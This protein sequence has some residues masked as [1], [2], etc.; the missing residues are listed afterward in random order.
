VLAANGIA[1]APE[2]P[3]TWRAFLRSHAEV[4]AAVDFFTTEVWT[5]RGLVTC[6]TLFAIDLRTRVVEMLGSTLHPDGAFMAQ[7]AR[8]IIDPIDGF[9]RKKRYLLA[10]RDTKFTARFR[11]IL[12]QGGVHC[13][14]LPVAA[15]NS[16]AYAER[17][18]RSIKSECLDRLILIGE[19][20]LHRALREY[21]AHYNRERNHQGV[22][23]RLLQPDPGTLGA[24]GPVECRKR[25]GGLL[26]YYFRRAAA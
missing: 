17:F 25:L 23:N 6:Y 10:D 1:P 4:I 24:T 5:T 2:R 14:R 12:E 22:G 19:G 11:A 3:M 8:N 26:R 9:L 15:P 13:L 21:V 16:N 18:V 20:S 7:V